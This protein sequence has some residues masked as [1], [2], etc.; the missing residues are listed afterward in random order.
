MITSKRGQI[1]IFVIIAIV[2]IVSIGAYFLFKEIATETII[3]ISIEPV[4]TSFIDCVE[5]NV[6]TGIS[7][8]EAKGGYIN[9][10]TLVLGSKYMPFSS[11]LNFLGV[12]VPYWYY[13][14]GSNLPKS[15]VPTIESM[16]EDL[17]EYL[18]QSIN[19][20]NFN[21]Y[22]S[23]GYKINLAKG[24]ADV[25]I[26]GE[27]IDVDLNADL[28][29]EKDTDSSVISNHRLRIDSK[30]GS[31]YEEALNIYNKEQ[32]EFFLEN[33]TLDVL[34]L[35][36]PVDGVEVR[37]SP[38]TWDARTIESDLKEALEVNTMALKNQ[39]EST[40]YFVVDVSQDVNVK[41]LY[42]RSWPTYL[43]IN[44]TEGDLLIS[45]PIGNQ[46]GMGMIGFCYVPYHFVYNFRHPV[47]VQVSDG[48]ETFQ[49]PMVVLIEGNL[50]RKATPSNATAEV[51]NDVCKYKNTKM[52]VTLY[53]SNLDPVDGE[54]SFSCV[55]MSCEIGNT[56]EGILEGDF[57]QCVNGVLKVRAEGYKDFEL[58]YSTMNE[59]NI[60]AIL[61]KEYMKE[62]SLII[63]GKEY[64]KPAVISF[65]GSNSQAL[66]YPDS[67]EIVLSPGEYNFSVYLYEN[68][69][70]S[71]PKTEREQCF[72]V[73]RSGVLGIAG[74]TKEQCIT[75]TTEEQVITNA[76]VGGGSGS[77]YVSEDDLVNFET[78]VI[79]GEKLNSPESLEELQYNYLLVES[80]VMGAEF[81]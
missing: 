73:P 67:K 30:L 59:G 76:V 50:P 6:L 32:D 80:N 26:S 18:E 52:K 44:P 81:I 79:S 64:N 46:Q 53:D 63:D 28:S 62:F 2:L 34:R 22:R 11:Q 74:F 66:N 77:I 37:C 41:F 25:E 47:L 16:E 70:L 71:L 33:Y 72:S 24:N 61:D 14:S 69:T 38:I 31:L 51:E 8:L 65:Y 56:Q 40:D 58:I 20:C 54:I 48:G 57:P 39:G 17:E 78:F 36:A 29:V 35:Y 23:E 3:P 19:S 27:Y 55:G 4:E 75:V 43:E 9:N 10:P 21:T 68:S 42:S 15:Q 60:V 1:T 45:K 13:V 49:F 12:N 5:S 7:I